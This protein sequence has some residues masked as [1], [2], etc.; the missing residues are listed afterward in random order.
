M[1]ILIASELW[2][3]G[4]GVVKRVGYI[5]LPEVGGFPLLLGRESVLG[6]YCP[7]V[8]GNRMEDISRGR[9][10]K[11]AWG[12][13]HEQIWQGWWKDKQWLLE[14]HY[15]LSSTHHPTP[16]SREKW[17]GSDVVPAARKSLY[18]STACSSLPRMSQ[19]HFNLSKLPIERVVGKLLISAD[20]RILF[21]WLLQLSIDSRSLDSSCHLCVFQMSSYLFLVWR[22][23]RIDF[24]SN[25]PSDHKTFCQQ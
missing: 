21:W 22:L 19:D 18:L 25:L 12:W 24:N 10:L 17:R 13:K 5:P 4:Y 8:A 20:T 3:V 23:L 2:T 6:V 15:L 16:N 1:L 7:R 9:Q 11:Q 14:P